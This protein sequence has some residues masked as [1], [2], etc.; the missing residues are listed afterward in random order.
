MTSEEGKTDW[1]LT[2]M[3]RHLGEHRL[4]D[5]GG[6]QRT[7]ATHAHAAIRTL[8][9]VELAPETMRAALESLAVA[10]P[11]LLMGHTPAPWWDRYAKRADDFRP[12]RS[13]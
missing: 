9:R 8:N 1:L 11:V 10:A 6:R 7:D 12:P 4:L 2:P 13:R 3:L 5:R